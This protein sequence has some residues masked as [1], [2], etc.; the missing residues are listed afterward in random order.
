MGKVRNV[1]IKFDS[2]QQDAVPRC[3]FIEGMLGIV[4]SKG[5]GAGE[6]ETNRCT[7]RLHVFSVQHEGTLYYTS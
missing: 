3:I 5:C 2:L 6:R 7:E 1:T 4:I